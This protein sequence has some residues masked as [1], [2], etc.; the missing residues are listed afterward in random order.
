[1]ELGAGS[2]TSNAQILYV[3]YALI[4]AVIAIVA[5]A[6]LIVFRKRKTKI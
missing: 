6:V 5:F 1:M 4:G 2:S 3:E